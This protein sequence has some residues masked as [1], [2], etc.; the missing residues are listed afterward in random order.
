MSG[1]EIKT[2]QNKRSGA[3]LSRFA[4]SIIFGAIGGVGRSQSVQVI[5]WG[6]EGVMSLAENSL[7]MN[8]LQ[9]MILLRVQMEMP[10][11]VIKG[12]DRNNCDGSM[13]VDANGQCLGPSFNP[14]RGRDMHHILRTG[15]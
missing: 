5:V 3:L 2:T 10:L 6:C 11:H 7:G 12:M 14:A 9:D 4:G 1:G 13:M 8:H 15:N